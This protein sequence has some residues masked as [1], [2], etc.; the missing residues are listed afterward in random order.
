MDDILQTIKQ[1]ITLDCDEG[2][3]LGRIWEYVGLAQQKLHTH[4]GV[5]TDATS[6]DSELK[7]YLWPF[8]VRMQGML[9]INEGTTIYDGA[10][11]NIADSEESQA[12]IRLD[13]AAVEAQYP[14]VIVRASQPA[15]YRMLFGREE[16][17]ERVLNSPIGT[18]FVMCLSRAREKGVTQ[19]RLSRDFSVDAR[20]TFHYIK[21]LDQFGLVVKFPT[22]DN[23][24]NTNLLVLRRFVADGQEREQAVREQA[25]QETQEAAD[26]AEE[27]EESGGLARDNTAVRYMGSSNVRERVSEILQASETEYMVE[28]DLFAALDLDIWSNPHHKYFHRTMRYLNT[29]GYVETVLIQ[30]PNERQSNQSSGTDDPDAAEDQDAVGVVEDEAQPE[31]AAENDSGDEDAE[32]TRG[33]ERPEA[34]TSSNHPPAA[35]GKQQSKKSS[36]K[37]KRKPKQKKSNC[38]PG[39][40]YRRCV[41]LIKPYVNKRKVRGSVGIPLLA[42]TQQMQEDSDS[43]DDDANLSSSGDEAID[44]NAAKEKDDLR[45]MLAKPQVLLGTLALLPID[46][47]I[48]RMV[49][50]SG[51]YGIVA[52][53]IQFLM[54]EPDYRAV[55]QA[56]A[57][58]ESAPLFTPDG[59]FPGIYTSPEEKQRNNEIKEGATVRGKNEKMAPRLLARVDE[60]FGREHRHRYFVNPRAQPLIDALTAD[61]TRVEDG[62]RVVSESAVVRRRA[63][64][65]ASADAEAAAESG[66]EPAEDVDAGDEADAEDEAEVGAPRNGD[67]ATPAAS[68]ASERQKSIAAELV[69]VEVLFEEAKSRRIHFNAVVREHAALKM[70]EHDSIIELKYKT[71]KH[72][73]MICKAYYELHKNSTLFTP[74]M[75]EAVRKFK[76]DKRTFSRTVERL[77]DEGRARIQIVGSLTQDGP[78]LLTEPVVLKIAMKRSMDPQDALVEAFINQMRDRRAFSTQTFPK[79]PRALDELVP[80]TRA[81]GAEQ[82]DKRINW[83]NRRSNGESRGSAINREAVGG[84]R[85]R[86]QE[87]YQNALTKRARLILDRPESDTGIDRA[88]PGL[89]RRLRSPPWRIGRAVDL[90]TYLAETVPNAIDGISIFANNGFRTGILF[91]KIP[92]SLYLEICGGIHCLPM[93]LPYIR[94]GQTVYD[95][96]DSDGEALANSLPSS[97][98]DIN[99]RLAAPVGDLPPKIRKAALGHMFRA[100]G[101]IQSLLFIL[102]VLQLIRPVH[103]AKEIM[104]LPSP[105][106]AEDAFKRVSLDNPKA[107]VYGYQIIGRARQLSRKG[108]SQL[109]DA[110]AA[111]RQ[112][113]VDLS[114]AYLNDESYDMMDSNGRFQYFSDLEIAA[115]KLGVGLPAQHPLFGIG[116][117]MYWKRA[118]K[119]LKSQTQILDMYVDMR[120]QTTPMDSSDQLR[121]AA[122]QAGT[123]PEDARR[124]YQHIHARMVRIA[125]REKAHK[126]RKAQMKA[127]VEA[128]RNREFRE[129]Q[130][131]GEAPP[132]K[133]VIRRIPFSADETLMVFISYVVLRRH[134]RTHR[135]PFIYGRALGTVFPTRMKNVNPA[136]DLRH[137]R[138]RMLKA[139]PEKYTTL[140]ADLAAVWKFVQRD[141]VERGELM[142]DPDIST[143]DLKASVLYFDELLQHTPLDQLMVKYAHDIAADAERLEPLSSVAGSRER[144]RQSRTQRAAAETAQPRAPPQPRARKKQTWR[145]PATMAGQSDRFIIDDTRTRAREMASCEFSE[146]LYRDGMMHQGR[147]D[148]MYAMV[149][150]THS[151][152]RSAA[153]YSNPVSTMVSF[154]AEPPAAESPDRMEVDSEAAPQIR[155]E[156][157]TRPADLPFYPESMSRASSVARTISAESVVKRIRS[158]LDRSSNGMLG[159]PADENGGNAVQGLDESSF[160]AGRRFA[161]S[162]CMQT[163]VMNLVLTPLRE[164]SVDIGHSLLS[165][166]PAMASKAFSS[167]A[168]NAT[169]SRLRGMASAVGLDGEQEPGADEG[170]MRAVRSIGSTVVVYETTGSTRTNAREASSVGGSAA[171]DQSAAA[172]EDG[173]ENAVVASTENGGSAEVGADDVGPES[174][175]AADA[176]ADAEAK[177]PGGGNDA[178]DDRMVPGR[179][180][181]VSDKFLHAIKTTLPEDFLD[182]DLPQRYQGLDRH[183]DAAEFRYVCGLIGEG[184]LWIRPQYKPQAGKRVYGMAGFKRHDDV[185]SGD[186]SLAVVASEPPNVAM[187]AEAA[188]TADGGELS[189]DMRALALRVVRE[190]VDIMGPLGASALELATLLSKL[191]DSHSAQLLSAVP[192]AVQKALRL[193]RLVAKL[194]P[195]LAA[196]QQ[197]FAVGSNDRRYV[198]AA[199]YHRHWVLALDGGHRLGPRLGQNLSGSINTTLTAGILASVLGHI[200][201]SPGISQ[202]TLMRRHFAPFVSKFEVLC[203]LDLLL[204]MGIVRA[205]TVDEGIEAQGYGDAPY[206]LHITYYYLAPGYLHL[207]PSISATAPVSDIP[208]F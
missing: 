201:S 39:Y 170:A 131:R 178:P 181:S 91:E 16:G 83:R 191:A 6:V 58:L 87:S 24:S 74:A 162:V 31:E 177:A 80:V 156:A 4:N 187:D 13:Y 199:A 152:F 60:F 145:L 73:D 35:K 148:H 128:A 117:I 147:R 118:V 174:N 56:L 124:Y 140:E 207:L 32:T 166:N 133:P 172:D 97:I 100:R 146:D 9:F 150:T 18:K 86:A 79:K 139:Y 180:Y 188:G 33:E 134:A 103:S 63:D 206:P 68:A 107:M 183:L 75:V 137:H 136:E 104:E 110:I 135:H 49:A 167:L 78:R 77:A 99:Q 158:L 96:D 10:D 26:E 21:L 70:L 197:L 62:A 123:T 7:A 105:P 126:D 28:A 138:E 121:E 205:E 72:C 175:G 101:H 44:I 64:V 196:T 153:D 109:A 141:A 194:L 30:L 93:L 154:Q 184:K 84:R 40:S 157:V 190:V 200:F 169:I 116:N 114:N 89:L 47:Q 111:K 51:T 144:A 202:A 15:I 106:A 48:L 203:Y 92:L 155:V 165:L 115:R 182:A 8:I 120:A 90:Y 208:N 164:Y 85:K 159:E 193:E 143:F 59:G 54:R 76:L 129:M 55:T 12:F 41:R 27:A 61:F 108:Y 23:G 179:G 95:S 94:D 185:Y 1:E 161:E 88:W 173:A 69:P 11:P 19:A 98:N 34:S 65:P 71:A 186:F 195:E 163:L 189:A 57:R 142:D 204:E 127:M 82:R 2:S 45:N 176:D 53:A 22:Y 25:V 132:E 20:S 17:I 130:A 149:L 37:K 122:A 5:N 50:L 29:N 43:G 192:L 125:E 36:Q 198:S 52:K 171:V 67:E 38:R 160:A 151:G 81:E 102:Q 112:G 66:R 46:M 113:F 42:K 119:L 168:R 14:D 3:R